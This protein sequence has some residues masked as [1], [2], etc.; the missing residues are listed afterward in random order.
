MLK[1]R[2]KTRIGTPDFSIFPENQ[3]KKPGKRWIFSECKWS[4]AY[5][6][7]NLSYFIILTFLSN[8]YLLDTLNITWPWNGVIKGSEA[9][10][11]IVTN[12]II[13]GIASGRNAPDRILAI[14]ADQLANVNENRFYLKTDVDKC[15]REALIINAVT[16]NVGGFNCNLVPR[17]YIID[18]IL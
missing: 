16:V 2:K 13:G 11:Q 14:V 18:P 7:K 5:Y 4:N 1:I 9:K 12:A 8:C 15:A 6:E 17:K 3:D 10:D